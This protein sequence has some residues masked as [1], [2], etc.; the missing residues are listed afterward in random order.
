MFQGKSQTR[1]SERK[2]V[3]S[4]QCLRTPTPWVHW[5]KEDSQEPSGNRPSSVQVCILQ[6]SCSVVVDS[7]GGLVNVDI[8]VS[9]ATEAERATGIRAKRSS[10]MVVDL[11]LMVLCLI[12]RLSC[13][14]LTS[15]LGLQVLLA[16]VA[17]TCVA[18]LFYTVLPQTDKGSIFHLNR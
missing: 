5:Q 17:L 3:P 9:F 11:D 13:A 18:P 14:C 6:L 7:E 12:C 4:E 2:K 10:F 16:T 1:R 15:F 8:E